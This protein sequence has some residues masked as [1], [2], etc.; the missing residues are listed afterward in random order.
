MSTSTLTLDD[1]VHTPDGTTVMVS[2]GGVER[3][4]ALGGLGPLVV[5]QAVDRLHAALEAGMS[6]DDVALEL[7]FVDVPCR[8][9]RLAGLDGALLLDDTH[10]ASPDEVRGSLRVLADLGR[11]GLRT[12]AVIGPLQV[13]EHDRLDEHDAL[14]RIV[15]RLDVSQLVVIGVAARHLYMAASLEGSWNGE[16]VLFD[17]AASAYDFV[18]ATT[19][20]NTVILVSGGTHRAELAELVARLREGAS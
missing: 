4:I 8:T 15:V 7:P 11:C 2:A 14:G 20:P 19:G 17:D 18:R 3:T 16:S 13:D 9:Q 5:Q 6:L 10:A 12:V 1:V